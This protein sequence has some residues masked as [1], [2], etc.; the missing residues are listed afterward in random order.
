MLANLAY[1]DGMGNVKALFLSYRESHRRR[2]ENYDPRI[3][4][5]QTSTKGV[6]FA[7]TPHRG[8]DQTHWLTYG[9]RLARLLH[10]SQS[11]ELVDALKQGSW[12][13]ETLQD[14]FQDILEDFV[15][16]SLFEELS[17]PGVGM[18]WGVSI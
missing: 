1:S 3:A 15:V 6:I 7:G 16:Y 9:T 12:V 2:H 5:L 17:Y 13:L 10:K 11:P 18:V 14:E 8:S 4:S